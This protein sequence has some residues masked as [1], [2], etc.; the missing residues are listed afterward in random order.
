[1]CGLRGEEKRRAST[2]ITTATV[3]EEREEIKDGLQNNKE[4]KETGA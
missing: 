2:T 4:Q 1:V 3:R